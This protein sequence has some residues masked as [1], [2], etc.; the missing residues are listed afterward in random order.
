M[1]RLYFVCVCPMPGNVEGAASVAG[2]ST[3]PECTGRYRHA[4]RLNPRPPF[5]GNMLS[6]RATR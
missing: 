2:R 4:D 5:A 6:W 1:L 3:S